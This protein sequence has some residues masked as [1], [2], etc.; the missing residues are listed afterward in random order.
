MSEPSRG[1]PIQVAAIVLLLVGG[2]WYFFRHYQI[3]GL[4]G[5]AVRPKSDD[6]DL[7]GLASFSGDQFPENGFADQSVLNG[8]FGNPQFSNPDRFPGRFVDDSDLKSPFDGVN[9][10]RGKELTSSIGNDRR[11]SPDVKGASTKHRHLRIG[12]WALDGFGPTKLGNPVSRK[13]IVRIISQFDVVALQQIASIERDLV[14][15]LVDE[16]NQSQ[17]KFDYVVGEASGPAARQEQLAFVFDT[18]RVRVDRKQTYTVADPQNQ[19]TYDPVVAWFQASE[20]PASTAWTFSL[21]NVRVD[22]SRAPIEVAL[23]PKV[24]KSVRADGRGED[25]VVMAG[26]FQADD[27]YLVPTVADA[28]ASANA[29]ALNT[30]ALDDRSYSQSSHVRAAVRSVPTDIFGRHQ[31]SN[32][33]MDTQLC[34]EFLGRGGALDFLRVYNLTLAEA[35]VVSSHLPV[36]GEFTA[37]EGGQL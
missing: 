4:D 15:R 6:R 20:P 35:E 33:L 21:V 31:T 16:I 19:M 32:I 26:L 1:N 27:A 17:R 8:S 3:Q 25:D 14:P 12:S 34:R 28:A 36:F 30:I 2:G 29:A 18:S 10:F 24:L 9:P 37:I 5:I 7:V 22:L 11:F 23:L 13:N